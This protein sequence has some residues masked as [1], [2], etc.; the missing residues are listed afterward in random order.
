MT[1]RLRKAL[2]RT[3]LDPIVSALARTGVSPNALSGAGLA[4]T[5]AAGVLAAEGHLLAA[6]LVS[7]LGGAF[8]ALD[9]ALARATRQASTFGA[10]LDSTLDRYGEAAVLLGILVYGARGGQTDVLL[11]AGLALTGSFMVSYVRARAEGLGLD[12]E[13]GILTRAERI[14]VLALGLITGLVVP[15]LA[16]VAV[17]ANVTAVQRLS[18]VWHLTRAC[19]EVQAG[20][21][22]RMEH[23]DVSNASSPQS[24]GELKDEY[25]GQWLAVRVTKREGFEPV[26]ALLIHHAPTRKQIWEKVQ[27]S[28]LFVFYAGPIVPEGHALA[29]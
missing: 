21:L 17:L 13:V 29:L 16:I 2:S 14:I 3:R 27:E 1:E 6:G 22:G 4:V 19:L 25:H 15:A 9:G 11:L 26:E 20:R 12:C 5:L 8:D 10:L 28:G 23:A 7:L 18:Y 24:I